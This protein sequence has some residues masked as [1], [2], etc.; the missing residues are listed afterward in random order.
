[1]ILED[2]ISCS[3]TTDAYG[4]PGLAPLASVCQ[5]WRAFFEHHI[6]RRLVLDND[7]IEFFSKALA[8]PNDIRIRYIKHIWLRVTLSPYE[9]PDCRKSESWLTRSAFVNHQLCPSDSSSSSVV[10]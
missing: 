6:F 3:L 7:D 1:M 5:E 9:C 10:Y 2:V 8:S 4:K